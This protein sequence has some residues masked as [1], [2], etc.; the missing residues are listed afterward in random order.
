MESELD[1]TSALPSLSGRASLS[2][3]HL[4]RNYEEAKVWLQAKKPPPDIDKAGVFCN[5]RLDL[6]EVEVYGYD[7][8]TGR[9]QQILLCLN[10]HSLGHS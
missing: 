1:M 5:D 2:A 8:G 7:Y 10:H 3:E 9:L 4:W 6:S